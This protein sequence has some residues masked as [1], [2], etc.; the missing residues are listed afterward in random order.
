[1]HL[2]EPHV[3]RIEMMRIHDEGE[4]E[5]DDDESHHVPC[6]FAQQLQNVRKSFEPPSPRTQTDLSGAV[7][8]MPW[9]D[10]PADELY[11]PIENTPD[12]GYWLYSATR[13]L[14]QVQMK[15]Q[16]DSFRMPHIVQLTPMPTIS[17][18]G[19]QIIRTRA[20]PG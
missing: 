5:E 16:Q 20:Q 7:P 11:R 18:L 12:L 15:S 13:E 17:Q 9:A 3:R 4:D 14:C 2:N 1:M 10:Q 19:Y 6:E 8:R